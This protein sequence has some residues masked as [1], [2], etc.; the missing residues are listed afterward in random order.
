MSGLRAG[1]RVRGT[2]LDPFGLASLR[3]AERAMVTEYVAAID[4]LVAGFGPERAA[5]AAAIASLPDQVRGYEHLKRDRMQRYRAELG[6][7]L[8]RF[9]QP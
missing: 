3:R 9:G 6:E 4:T 5:E 7:R 1:R 2:P 8:A